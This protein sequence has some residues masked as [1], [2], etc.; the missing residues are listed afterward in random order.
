M[1]H[2]L[3]HLGLIDDHP[4]GIYHAA[5]LTAH[6]AQGVG[7]VLVQHLHII[8]KMGKIGTVLLMYF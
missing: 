2:V 5:L 8:D 3:E 1:A 4:H 6:V 7:K